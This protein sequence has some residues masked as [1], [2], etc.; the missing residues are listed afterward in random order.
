MIANCAT[1]SVVAND[2]TKTCTDCDAMHKLADD[3]S[4]C[5]EVTAGDCSAVD[6]TA[7]SDDCTACPATHYLTAGGCTLITVNDGTAINNC[8]HYDDPADDG[9]ITCVKC[10]DDYFV[11]TGACS[12]T[13]VTADTPANCDFLTDATN[14]SD[15]TTGYALD[16]N[17][18]TA[19]VDETGNIIADCAT[20]AY[21][22]AGGGAWTCTECDAGKAL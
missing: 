10:D 20:H 16:A 9:T 21:T 3:G 14:C 18:T 2:G 7:N 13:G 1:Y 8:F 12:N 5:T 6:T 19:C 22:S 15:C 17:D 4:T 11:D